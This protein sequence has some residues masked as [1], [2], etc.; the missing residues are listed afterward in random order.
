MNWFT[1]YR[2]ERSKLIC[3]KCKEAIANRVVVDVGNA[4][5]WV[6]CEDCL[7]VIEWPME[8]ISKIIVEKEPLIERAKVP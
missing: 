8:N 4:R 6:L 5:F 1:R 7:T 3:P 2:K